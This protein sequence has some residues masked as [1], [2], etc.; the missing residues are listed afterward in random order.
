[1]EELELYDLLLLKQSQNGD[2][3]IFIKFNKHNFVFRLISA[4]EYTQCKILTNDDYTFHDAICQLA[5][6]YPEDY[7]FAESRIG[8]V[9]D[10]MAEQIIDKS[11]IFKDEKLV[12]ILEQNR[13]RNKTF[14]RECKLLVKAAFP[15]YSLEEI[16]NWAYEK[17]MEM[18]AAGERL[19]QLRNPLPMF[20]DENIYKVGYELDEEKIKNKNVVPSDK[21]LW[22]QG[23]D[24]MI[25]K[26][27]MIR[28]KK[29]LIDDPLIMGNNWRD[30]ELNKKVGR[31]IFRR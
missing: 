2:K 3:L 19:L 13:E 1:M 30:E 16:N 10:Y 22:E 15:E 23:I 31:Q 14:L 5:L 20:E 7:S 12:E 27:P 21:E 17:L 25:Y 28:L 29:P 18:T 9:S 8:C 24:P 26:S 4:D 11:L 6:V